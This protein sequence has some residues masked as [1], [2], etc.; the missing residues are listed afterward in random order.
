MR[1]FN[2]RVANDPRF[3]T[4]VIPVR[5]GLLAALRVAR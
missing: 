2:E 3:V 1:E 5:D 4:A